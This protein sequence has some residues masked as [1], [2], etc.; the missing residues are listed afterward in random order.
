MALGDGIR[1]NLATVSKVERDRL[2]DAIIKLQTQYHF[3][4]LRSD[5][6]SG[7]VSWWFKQDEIHAHTHVHGVPAFVPW[8]REL[9]NRFEEM[10]RT[11]DPELSLHYWDWTQDPRTLPD[12]LGGTI[13]LFAS[14]FLGS[15]SGPAGDPLQANGFYVPGA[16]PARDVS[17]NPFDPPLDVS[18]NMSSGRAVASDSAALG[19][20]KFKDFHDAIKRNHDLAHGYVGGTLGNPHTSFRDPVAFFLHSNLDRLFAMWQRDPAHPERLD[21]AHVYDYGPGDWINPLTGAPE[22]ETGSGDVL[23]LEPWWGFSSPLEPWAS[24]GAQTATTG[25]VANVQATRP[26]APPENQQ[27]FKDCR[28]PSVVRPPSYDTAPSPPSHTWIQQ[29]PA[30]SPPARFGAC[31]AFDAASGQVILFGGESYQAGFGD[32][33]AW[34]GRNWTQLALA[35]SP[36]GVLYGHMAF[37]PTRGVLVLWGGAAAGGSYP[38]D[39][40]TWNGSIWTRQTPSV[41]PPGRS[42]GMMAWD[43]ERIILYGGEANNVRRAD[44]WAWDG[45]DWTKLSDSASPGIRVGAVMNYFPDNQRLVMQGG[46][47]DTQTLSDTWQWDRANWTPQYPV[48]N[49]GYRV[50]AAAAFDGT[51]VLVFGGGQSAVV[52]LLGDLWAWDGNSWS[53]LSNQGP[54]PR[55][56]AALAQHPLGP[57]VVLFGGD[58]DVHHQALGDTWTYGASPPPTRCFVATALFGPLSPEVATLRAFRDEWLLQHALGRAL[59]RNYYRQGPKLAALTLRFPILESAMRRSIRVCIRF[60]GSAPRG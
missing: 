7:G 45:Q 27:V 47:S 31:M 28:D 44:M 30:K 16:S 26:W 40:W 53:A 39:T 58:D 60:L 25:I 11:V 3:P 6:P 19:A 22:P 34:D 52:P 32:T 24:P 15:S 57:G 43:G 8:H 20:A 59:V 42:N 46:S 29:T 35:T 56:E 5:T 38:T 55:R 23:S 4:G 9:I 1:R 13:N 51:R 36:P 49:P 54:S 14:D 2:R 18:R 10:I 21:P 17:D 41:S 33:W 37:D 12:G 50:A 48:A